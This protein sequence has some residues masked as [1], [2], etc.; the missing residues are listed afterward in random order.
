MENS[1]DNEIEQDIN[2]RNF[3]N[4]EKITKYYTFTKTKE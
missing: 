3:N 2:Q 4:I 1:D